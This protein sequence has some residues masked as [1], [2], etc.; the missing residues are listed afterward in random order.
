MG[1]ISCRTWILRLAL[2]MR[3]FID[4][5]ILISIYNYFI[6]KS[7]CT[8][9]AISPMAQQALFATETCSFTPG[10]CCAFNQSRKTSTLCTTKYVGICK[11]QN[12]ILPVVSLQVLKNL[13]IVAVNAQHK[14]EIL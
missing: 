7:G 1:A 13:P 5:F 12:W 3:L 8:F 6:K 4:S 9:T 11:I 14:P 2:P 10:A